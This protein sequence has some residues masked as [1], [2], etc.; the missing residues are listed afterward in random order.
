[1]AACGKSDPGAPTT[2]EAPSP[3]NA[4]PAVEANAAPA[5]DPALAR[6]APKERSALFG[7]CPPADEA[8]EAG[9]VALARAGAPC[10]AARGEAAACADFVARLERA[11]LDASGCVYAATPRPDQVRA[12]LA[13]PAPDI[14]AGLSAAV[15]TAKARAAAGQVDAAARLVARVV[16]TA[17]AVARGDDALGGPRRASE[18]QLRAGGVDGGASEEGGGARAFR[19]SNTY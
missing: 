12:P 17:V 14:A 13:S 4:D 2:V 7:R 19:S 16:R 15:A 18:L 5:L 11:V 1:M 6:L 3:G 8:A 10:R 9:I